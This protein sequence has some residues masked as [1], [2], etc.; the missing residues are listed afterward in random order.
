MKGVRLKVKLR[1]QKCSDFRS[2]LSA[3]HVTWGV[4]ERERER[5]RH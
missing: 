3:R 4:N 5:E 2:L 1:F